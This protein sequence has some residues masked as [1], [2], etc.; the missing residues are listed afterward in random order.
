MDMKKGRGE[1]RHRWLKKRGDGGI[2]P[3]AMKIEAIEM[4]RPKTGCQALAALLLVV[5]LLIFLCSV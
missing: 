5:L 2:I 3:S 4:N 1:L